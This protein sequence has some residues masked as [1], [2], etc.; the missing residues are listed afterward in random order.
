M[1]DGTPRIWQETKLNGEGLSVSTYIEHDE[2]DAKVVS[3]SYWTWSELLHLIGEHA[4]FMKTE[5]D[6]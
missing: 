2:D 4:S 1:S 3:E 5:S 6:E